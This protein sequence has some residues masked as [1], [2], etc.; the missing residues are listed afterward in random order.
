MI[1]RNE[2]RRSNQRDLDQTAAPQTNERKAGS[3]DCAVAPLGNRGGKRRTTDKRPNDRRKPHQ[4]T[5]KGQI[6]KGDDRHQLA[7]T[8]PATTTIAYRVQY[9]A[10]YQPLG[11][12]SLTS[13]H[14]AASAI[15]L[16]AWRENRL[17]REPSQKIPVLTLPSCW[18]DV[19]TRRHHDTNTSTS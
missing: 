11:R 13:V 4:L 12:R 17:T 18:F 15:P 6:K 1:E 5:G 2:S 9:R 8:K 7:A 19:E 10:E 16:P 3:H 14:Q